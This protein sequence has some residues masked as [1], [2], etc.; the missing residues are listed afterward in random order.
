MNAQISK[1]ENDKFCLHNLSSRNGE[2]LT[3]ISLENSLAC[4]DTKFLKR[5]A[6]L[7]S[8]T[9]PNNA[10]AQLDYILMNKKGMNSILNCEA[11]SSFEGVSSDH[12]II[13]VKIHLS[14][15][16]NKKKV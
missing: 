12:R 15:C 1:N 14:L 4:Q 5:E 7:W 13:S 11:Y 9:Y 10:K 6:K 3:D 2:Y 8:Y 16:R